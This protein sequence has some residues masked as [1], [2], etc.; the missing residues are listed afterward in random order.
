M[1]SDTSPTFSGA[2]SLGGGEG[3]AGYQIN[4]RRHDREEYILPPRPFRPGA[5]FGP[6]A[7][8]SGR[9]RPDMNISPADSGSM[10]SAGS[11]QDRPLHRVVDFAPGGGRYQCK[12]G[13]DCGTVTTSPTDGRADPRPYAGDP[14][15]PRS[16]TLLDPRRRLRRAHRL[17]DPYPAGEMEA[18]ISDSVN[19][20][21]NDVISCIAPEARLPRAGTLHPVDLRELRPVIPER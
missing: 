2:S 3:E 19:N 11:A 21:R 14:R 1:G 6:T 12:E 8:T 17:L 18:Y 16:F 20:S 13:P 4:I 15:R 5:S 9:S 7:F 10:G